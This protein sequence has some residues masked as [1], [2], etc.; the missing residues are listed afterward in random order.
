MRDR[1]SEQEARAMAEMQEPKM[2]GRTVM[3]LCRDCYERMQDQ[4]QQG[5]NQPKYQIWEAGREEK[6]GECSLRHEL[7]ELH[8]YEWYDQ[9]EKEKRDRRKRTQ[10]RNQGIRRDTRAFYRERYREGW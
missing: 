10:E 1:T 2:P 7:A 4:R 3:W 9:E 6:F 8:L 5:S